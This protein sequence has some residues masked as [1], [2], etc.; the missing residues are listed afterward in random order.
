MIRKFKRYLQREKFINGIRRA[1]ITAVK[2]RPI[3]YLIYRW[4][5][6]AG[7]FSNVEVFFRHIL[8]CDEKCYVPI[9][10]MQHVRSSLIS[11]EQNAWEWFF[12]QPG[13]CSLEEGLR[14][15]RLKIHNGK[16]WIDGKYIIKPWE[17]SCD[18]AHVG[19]YSESI[20]V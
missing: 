14:S 5:E 7:I 18:L 4:N 9:I 15:N 20:F 19:G 6:K 2:N 11:G 10:D 16:D 3:F 12:E 8:Y 13:E 1:R 17:K